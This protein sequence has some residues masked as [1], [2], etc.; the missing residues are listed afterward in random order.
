MSVEERF[1]RTQAERRHE[2][3]MIR[4][5]HGARAAVLRLAST[6]GAATRAY[7]AVLVASEHRAILMRGSGRSDCVA[8]R[9]EIH[10]PDERLMV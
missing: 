8:S 6:A 7:A 5:E 2:S 4:L 9:T 10:E 3:G 1:Y